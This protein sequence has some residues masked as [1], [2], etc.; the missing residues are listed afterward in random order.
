MPILAA[1]SVAAIP[2]LRAVVV[3][4]QIYAQHRTPMFNSVVQDQPV[5]CT[6]TSRSILWTVS[7]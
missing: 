6:R 5:A 3:G 7:G 4:K 2:E 1:N